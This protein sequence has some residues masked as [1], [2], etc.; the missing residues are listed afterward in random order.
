MP[1]ARK[2][3]KES[4][5]KYKQSFHDFLSFLRKERLQLP[6]KRDATD[7]LVSDYLEYPWAQGE[8]RAAASTFMAALQDYE[9]KLRHNR[10]DPGD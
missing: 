7:G 9:R 3:G 6:T 5:K 1:V 8:G 2:K 10:L 4:A